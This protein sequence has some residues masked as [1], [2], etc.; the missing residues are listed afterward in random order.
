MKFT[1]QDAEDGTGKKCHTLV[2]GGGGVKGP[3]ETGA[4]W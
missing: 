2:M 4:F 1:L 3:Y